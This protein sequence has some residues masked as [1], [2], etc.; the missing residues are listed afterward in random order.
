MCVGG[1]H[2]VGGSLGIV[3][4]GVFASKSWNP[5]GADGLLAGNASFFL[6]EV[7]AVPLATASSFLFTYGMLWVID[8]ATPVRVTAETE[9]GGLDQGLHGEVAYESA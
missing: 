4:L 9:E 2:G 7:G 5:A 3:L 6:V 1:V 8:K